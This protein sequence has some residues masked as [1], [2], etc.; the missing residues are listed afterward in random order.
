VAERQ[1]DGRN[2]DCDGGGDDEGFDPHT[3][4]ATGGA[5]RIT[6]TLSSHA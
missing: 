1:R 5:D 2:D 3:M 4:Y 6:A